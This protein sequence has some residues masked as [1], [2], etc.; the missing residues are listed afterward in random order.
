MTTGTNVAA[1]LV[2]SLLF[3]LAFYAATILLL[4]LPLPVYFFLPRS[5][6]MWVVTTWGRTG[7][8]LLRTIAGTRL[9]V[10]GRETVPE[11]GVLI[12]A[13]HQSMFET[14]ALVPLFR[15][16]TFVMKDTIK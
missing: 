11:G 16:P 5:F 7:I 13:K 2:R 14:F 3:N 10:R 4:I 8:F 1:V 15:D 9:E 6:A 12:A